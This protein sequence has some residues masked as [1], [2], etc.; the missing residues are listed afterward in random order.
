MPEPRKAPRSPD[1]KSM[2]ASKMASSPFSSLIGS[3]QE[4]TQQC[5]IRKGNG[6]GKFAIEA[7][8]QGHALALDQLDLSIE[9][10]Y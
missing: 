4:C 6:S 9:F 10:R 8:F 5:E 3:G 1:G 7:T 2:A